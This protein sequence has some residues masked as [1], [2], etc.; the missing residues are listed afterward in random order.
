MS[1]EQ[2]VESR[3][4]IAVIGEWKID[5]LEIIFFQKEALFPW[6]FVYI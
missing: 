1:K 4:Q 5:S 6:N 2:R 3:E